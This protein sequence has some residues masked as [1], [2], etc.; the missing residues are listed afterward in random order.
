MPVS[1]RVRADD[2][3]I[4]YKGYLIRKAGH[5]W[6]VY[7][8]ASTYTNTSG[9]VMIRGKV[10]RDVDDSVFNFTSQADAEQWIDNGCPVSM[11]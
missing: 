4:D 10:M 3:A 11:S 6:R 8:D 1:G 2:D 9:Q 7:E 5:Q